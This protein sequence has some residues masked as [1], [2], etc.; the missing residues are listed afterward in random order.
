MNDSKDF[1]DSES[2]RSGN[3]HVTSQ[4]EVFPKLH[5]LKDCWGLHSYR[6][7]AQMG[8]QIFGMHPVYQETFLQIHMHLH[9]LF[10][11]QNWTL[12]GRKLLKNRFTCL[13][14]R[15]VE[16]QNDI[17]IWDA[18]LDRKPK[19]QSSSVE[20]TLQ[21]IVGQTNNDSRFRISI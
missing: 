7:D 5:L 15:K 13:Q 11:V 1:Q 14:R 19:I 3:S 8:R 4:P 16:D 20:E 10:I 17:K 12:F 9:Q 2:V 6:R 21:R 18:S